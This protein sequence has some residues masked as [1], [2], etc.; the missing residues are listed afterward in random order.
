MQQL[1]LIQSGCQQW[2]RQPAAVQ[3]SYFA[4]CSS[5]AIYVHAAGDHRLLKILPQH[6]QQLSAVCWSPVDAKLL[7]CATTK[8]VIKVYQAENEAV[9]YSTYVRGTDTVRKLCWSTHDEAVLLA[10]AGSAVGCWSYRTGD[11]QTLHT[12]RAT[13]TCMQQSASATRLLAVGCA[14]CTF[15]LY[16]LLGRKVR[17]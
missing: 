3:Q 11:W 7:A 14:D 4:V 2:I 9:V 8:Q 10:Y 5:L 1:H 12:F 13:V 15:H 16:D 17:C 6:D